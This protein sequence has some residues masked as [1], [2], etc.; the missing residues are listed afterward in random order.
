MIIFYF[1]NN[2]LCCEKALKYKRVSFLNLFTCISFAS[3]DRSKETLLWVMSKCVLS[4][5]LL[6]LWFQGLHWGLFLSVVWGSVLVSYFYVSLLFSQHHW[7]KRVFVSHYIPLPPLTRL[8]D[9]RYIGFPGGSGGHESTCNVGDLGSI[10]GWGR[11]PGEGKS[12]PLQYP[13]L[14]NSRDRGAGYRPRGPK[15][16]HGWVTAASFPGIDL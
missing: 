6:V 4:M 3:R 13:C 10:P 11:F 5:H 9:H 8:T 14:E 2:F 12:C 7:M 15:V 16:R 1:V